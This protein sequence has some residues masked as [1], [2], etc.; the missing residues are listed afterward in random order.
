MGNLVAATA[1]MATIAVGVVGTGPGV[2]AQDNDDPSIPGEGLAAAD[3]IGVSLKSGGL[4]IG[5]NLGRS[6]ASFTEGQATSRADALDLGALPQ[7]YGETSACPGETPVLGKAVLPPK[8][9]ADSQDAGS[10]ASRR[11]E[12]FMP[13]F[14]GNLT[15]ASAGFQDAIAT[16]QPSATALTDTPSQDAAIF[17]LVDPHTKVTASRVNGL[18]EASAVMWADKLTIMGGLIVLRE[19]RWEAVARSGTFKGNQG[20]F[21]FSGATVLGVNRTF[22]QATGDVK[23]F[24]KGLHDMLSNLGLYLDYP[25][26]TEIEGGVKVSPMQFRIT[27]MPLGITSLGPFIA[28]L[29]PLREKLVEDLSKECTNRAGLQL[30]DLVL[31]L[32]SGSGNVLIPVG[33]VEAS[34]KPT[35]FPAAVIPT[36]GSAGTTPP[37]TF[38]AP[39]PAAPVEVDDSDTARTFTSTSPD[40]GESTT[41][42]EETIPEVTEAPPTTVKKAVAKKKA[43]NEVAA[44]VVAKSSKP[45]SKSTTVALGVMALVG[46]LGLMVGDQVVMRRS[47]RRI[48]Q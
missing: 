39:A 27:N 32:L 47:R 42:P 36:D 29:Q 24:A 43:T 25:T 20:S 7:L 4:A 22:D 15:R 3:T 31:Q 23:S 40:L 34:T 44:P 14:A 19:P 2:S 1:L 17:Q 6:V 18:R 10:E 13:D 35:V 41:L 26:V 30:L 9:I 11:V 38:V 8:T 5:V 33:G 28:Q 12:A 37:E 48:I 46:A 16:G 45:T 21:T